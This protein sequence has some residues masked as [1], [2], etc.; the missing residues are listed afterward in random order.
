[1]FRVRVT[2]P[3]T[4]NFSAFT[5]RAGNGREDFW[6]LQ[7]LYPAGPAGDSSNRTARWPRMPRRR[8]P[9]RPA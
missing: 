2:R 8:R 4:D 3:K 5:A 7:S 6:L 1:M 9:D